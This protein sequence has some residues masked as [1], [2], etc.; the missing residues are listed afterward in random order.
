MRRRVGDRREI[1]E[2]QIGTPCGDTS[3]CANT[4]ATLLVIIMDTSRQNHNRKFVLMAARTVQRPRR[5]G[6]ALDNSFRGGSIYIMLRSSR[7]QEYRKGVLGCRPA[8]RSSPNVPME[9]SEC[10]FMEH[11]GY[12]IATMTGPAWEGC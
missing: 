12:E 10:S 8:P 3:A 2:R 7:Q 4:A 5:I 1:Y 6:L 9:I 11:S